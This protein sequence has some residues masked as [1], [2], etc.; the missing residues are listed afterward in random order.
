VISTFIFS[1]S[2]NVFSLINQDEIQIE[3]KIHK[4][5]MTI[6]MTL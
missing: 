6:L 5:S 4:N 3:K 1:F 2:F